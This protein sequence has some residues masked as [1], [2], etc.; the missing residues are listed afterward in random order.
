VRGQFTSSWPIR[1]EEKRKPSRRSRPA[2]FIQTRHDRRFHTSAPGAEEEGKEMGGRGTKEEFHGRDPRLRIPPGSPPFRNLHHRPG[3]LERL[4]GRKIRK[5]RLRS[6]PSRPLT[7]SNMIERGKKK[8]KK[9]A[10][11]ASN[12]AEVP[13]PF[14]YLSPRR[15]LRPRA[16][17]AEGRGE[18]KKE[19]KT[20]L[21]STRAAD[22]LLPLLA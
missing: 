11:L 17:E 13:P 16:R 22:F 3:V 9:T 21:A 14:C 8:K 5:G 20:L 7:S 6:K 4:R 19:E 10:S 1:R 12:L 18:G 2:A 15:S